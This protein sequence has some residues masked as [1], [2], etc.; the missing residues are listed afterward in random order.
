MDFKGFYQLISKQQWTEGR[1]PQQWRIQNY[2]HRVL[3]KKIPI[4]NQWPVLRLAGS[5]LPWQKLALISQSSQL[6]LQ[7]L[8]QQ[9]N[10]LSLIK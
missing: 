8:V 10:F 3:E 9:R 4:G 1:P 7:F 6:A 2:V 5:W